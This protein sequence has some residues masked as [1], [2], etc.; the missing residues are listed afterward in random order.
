[1]CSTLLHKH[2]AAQRVP[3]RPAP[4]WKQPPAAHDPHLGCQLCG[5]M[6]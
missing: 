5:I 6:L 1:L 3:S 2:A 4:E